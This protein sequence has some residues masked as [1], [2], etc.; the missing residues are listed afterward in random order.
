[1]VF[2]KKFSDRL[3]SL[4][5][6]TLRALILVFTAVG[7]FLSL[8]IPTALRPSN[9]EL[10]T[11]DVAA[12]D[13]LAP[14]A[15]E[16]TSE[17][18]TEKARKEAEARVSPVYLPADPAK[19]RLQV[20]KL[21]NM[22]AYIDLIRNDNLVPISQRIQDLTR[23]S[24]LSLTEDTARFLLELPVDT[25]KKIQ[26]ECV[27]VLM[28]VMRTPIREDQVESAKKTIAG[29]VDFSFS[30]DE[31]EIIVK[32]AGGFVAPNSIFSPEQT[33]IMLKKARD[34]VQPVVKKYSAGQIIVLRGQI[35]TE[36]VIEALKAYNLIRSKNTSQE[37]VAA[38]VYVIILA[39]FISIYFN[40]R[41]ISP[42]NDIRS[43]ALI[44]ITFIGFL[45]LARVSIPDRAIIPYV[46]PLPA[47]ALTL[48]V[49]FNF[50]SSFVLALIIAL[51]TGYG[52]GNSLDLIPFYAVSSL[53]GA[54]LLGKGRRVAD[55]FWAGLGIGLAGAA[56]IVAFRL[57]DQ[58]TDWVGVIT[59]IAAS[60]INGLASSS[61]AL[62][63][64]FIFSQILGLTTSLQLLDISRPDHPLMQ[65]ILRN[66]P[67]TYQHSLQVAN[68][69]E[70][71]AEAIG[72]DPILTRVG[73]IYHDAGKAANPQFFIENQIPGKPN[74]HNELDPEKS[75][76]IIISHVNDGVALAKKYRLPRRII[77]FM[78]EHHGTMITRYQYARAINAAGAKDD[79][80][81]LDHFRYPGPKPSSKETALLMLA[82]GCEARARAEMPKNETELRA[83][84]KKVIDH[85]QK[86][87]QLENT[88]L[89]FRDLTL[90]SE[91]IVNTLRNTYHPRIIYPEI[92]SSDSAQEGKND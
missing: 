70:Q 89:T 58:I 92:R 65:Y 82:D 57:P 25:W 15:K 18:L 20:E 74:P 85:C 63:L 50:E 88:N 19:S 26:D 71:A 46:F 49:L 83:L 11:G 77:D 59:L 27:S 55:F 87:G 41:K 52:L 64:Q 81:N 30:T 32:I 62:I 13:I 3:R 76:A 12:Q 22:L 60:L 23:I 91:S 56:V 54:L 31:A 53:F 24:S 84:V 80:V 51:L 28:Q 21:R 44:A 4:N 79:A 8:L 72:A 48:V 29:L 35:I 39:G 61:L 69:A 66:A 90:A 45:I 6:G 14:F 78:L 42:I 38:A 7:T 34:S 16:Y 9:F 86:E 37:T 73:A 2:E 36:E 75:A 17:V 33:E 43:L 10:S 68:I 47:F 1:M 5:R 40:R 67:G